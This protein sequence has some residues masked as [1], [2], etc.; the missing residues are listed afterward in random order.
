MNRKDFFRKSFSKAIAAVE[1]SADEIADAWKHVIQEQKTKEKSP[2]D[3]PPSLNKKGL[4]PK[5]EKIA[6]PQTRLPKRKKFKAFRNLQYPPGVDKTA[7]RFLSKC[8]GCGD[9][10]YA[11]PYSVLFP[12]MDDARG[13]HLPRMD[14][15]L[16]ACMLCKDYPCIAA[17]ETGALLPYKKKEDPKFGKANGWFQHCINARTGEKTCD[18]CALSC[19]IPNV[20]K[21]KSNKPTFSSDCVGCGQCVSACPTFPKAIIIK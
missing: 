7:K 9:C 18:A 5:Q 11:C 4:T 15:N 8:T 13:K 19:P 21:F 12:V 14:V 17:C 6:L 10:I 16:N 2:A 20:V 1:E 3:S